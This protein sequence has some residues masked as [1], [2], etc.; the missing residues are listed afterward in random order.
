MPTKRK[1]SG[2]PYFKFIIL[3]LFFISRSLSIAQLK[4]GTS[5]TEDGLKWIPYNHVT[6]HP[7]SGIL[8][9]EVLHTNP[10]KRGNVLKN[11]Y[12]ENDQQLYLWERLPQPY[13]GSVRR[14]YEFSNILYACTDQDIYKYEN[15]IWKSLNFGDKTGFGGPLMHIFPSGL[16]LASDRNSSSWKSEDEGKTWEPLY[17]R[18]GDVQYYGIYDIASTPDNWVLLATEK[19]IYFT[20]DEGKT[21]SLFSMKDTSVYSIACVPGGNFYASTKTGVYKTDISSVNWQIINM[22]EMFTHAL[23]TDKKGVL[24]AYDGD[25]VF[26]SSDSGSSWSTLD[27]YAYRIFLDRDDNLIICSDYK[28]YFANDKGV[29]F[30][31]TKAD[32]HLMS[33]FVRH[34]NEILTGKLSAGAALFDKQANSFTDCST[35]LNACTIRAILPLRN[36]SILISTDTKLYL[37]D[38]LGADFEPCFDSR[39]L[40]MRLAKDNSIFAAVASGIMRSD[41][42]G[43]SWSWININVAPYYISSFDISDDHRTICAGTSTGDIY[44]SHD[45]GHCFEKIWAADG[46]FA[47]GIKILDTNTFLFYTDALYITRDGGISVQPV[48]DIRKYSDVTE[49]EKD[50][51]GNIYLTCNDGVFRSLDGLRWN[52]LDIW[53]GDSSAW[54][55]RMFIRFDAED[56]V[57][58][59][60]DAGTVKASA[61]CGNRWQTIIGM[62]PICYSLW[63]FAIT[64]EG[65]VFCGSQDQGIFK[66]KASTKPVKQKPRIISGMKLYNNYPNPFN[67][68]TIIDFDVMEE[69]YVSLKIYDAL[70]REVDTIISDFLKEGTYKKSWNAA[71]FPSGAYYCRLVSS[72]KSEVLKMILLR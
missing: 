44:I 13:G 23:L 21:F 71:S 43:H 68:N 67:S 69:S 63:S 72:G 62:G 53:T 22:P 5:F 1:T 31:S 12:T 34:N 30:Q 66:I 61:D 18:N 45:A 70:G 6:Q 65:Y 55:H 11:A 46:N 26:R 35:G 17:F 27:L 4:S 39:S 40:F 9:S 59:G 25:R 3:I 41:D 37:S 15:K 24:Y 33:A 2:Y 60:T 36:G 52:K 54:R 42:N 7:A 38:N 49:I 50:R 56:N 10:I 29:Y 64:N 47:Y 14:F 8:N 28:L 51:K 48:Y 19:G 16:I 32:A 58:I 20:K 57:Y